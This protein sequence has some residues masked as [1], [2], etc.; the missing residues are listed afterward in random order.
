MGLDV[1]GLGSI[2]DFATTI[3]DKIFP[4]QD[5]ANKAKLAMLKMQQDGQFKEIETEF[6][7]ALKQAEIN[8]EEAKS[9]VWWKAGWRPFIGWVCGSA[10]AYNYVLMP[11]IV[12]F[13][14]LVYPAAP[15]MPL[16]DMG[17]LMTLLIGML[18]VGAM[19]SYDKSRI[20]SKFPIK[21]G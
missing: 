13:A 1:T 19:R 16:L 17:A 6:Q 9:E 3:I 5:E 8:L 7:L 20:F 15:P 10:L 2:F 12:W 21:E 11:F 4:N 14:A 18:G